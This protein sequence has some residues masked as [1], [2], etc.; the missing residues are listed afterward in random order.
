MMN[1][2]VESTDYE[3]DINPE[4]LCRLCLNQDQPLRSFFCSEI[5]DGK[6]VNLP[7]A[8]SHVLDIEIN[9]K[10]HFPDKICIAC[11]R[12]VQEFYVFKRKCREN[13]ELLKKLFERNLQDV[14]D[15]VAGSQCSNDNG[16]KTREYIERQVVKAETL[17]AESLQG[18]EMEEDDAE[19]GKDENVEE[20]TVQCPDCGGFVI[21]SQQHIHRLVCSTHIE[22]DYCSDD[23][24]VDEDDLKQHI[25]EVHTEEV[26]EVLSQEQNNR[27]EEDVPKNKE[28]D[29]NRLLEGQE[30]PLRDQKWHCYLCQLQFHDSFQFERHE[31][32]HRKTFPQVI[33]NIPMFRCANC[34]SIF[35][36]IDD[37][38]E[39]MVTK[40]TNTLPV[41]EE[42]FYTDTKYLDL[43]GFDD[44]APTLRKIV[45]IERQADGTTSCTH[46]GFISSDLHLQLQHAKEEHNDAADVDETP[47]ECGL[48]LDVMPNQRSVRQHL[49]LDHCKS[50]ECFIS[51]CD[52][53]YQTYSKLFQ[54]QL[55]FHSQNHAMECTHCFAIFLTNTDLVAHIRNDCPGRK[56]KCTT[57]E[58]K[59]LTLQGKKQHE[60]IHRQI[61]EHKCDLCSRCF[62]TRIELTVHNRLHTGEKPY[63]C[64]LCSKTFRTLSNKRD[65][66]STHTNERNYRCD[67][68]MTFFKSERTL[69]G[70]TK[71]HQDEKSHKCTECG[72]KFRRKQHL[73]AHVQ[74]HMK[75]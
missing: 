54:H 75:K 51:N 74:I 48:C 32:F 62:A 39:H 24:F 2:E 19:E 34:C 52:R 35:L 61:K 69:R 46:C 42:I 9:R 6:V 65:H 55:R 33:S 28:E 30:S 37:F 50:F 1:Q 53:S 45:S 38:Q 25:A 63:S 16:E 40:C 21:A 23:F 66:M 72:K 59:F 27:D 60:L 10:D 15:S 41:P 31:D 49:Y 57:C 3:L 13:N 68:C 73:A 26:P 29:S 11:R 12:K 36:D 56:Y 44:D 20:V 64:S 14:Q 5:I 18:E 4:L 7:A 67:I 70:H 17:D 43:C 8:A 22:C 47:H 71:I 58:K